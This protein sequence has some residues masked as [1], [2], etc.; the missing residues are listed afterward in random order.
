MQRPLLV[1]F[2]NMGEINLSFQTWVIMQIRANWI[3]NPT[4]LFPGIDIKNVPPFRKL[5]KV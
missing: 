5:T 3:S 2:G 1:D 4:V